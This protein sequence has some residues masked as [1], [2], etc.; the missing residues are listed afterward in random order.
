[1]ENAKHQPRTNNKLNG[2]LKME[3]SLRH[4]HIVTQLSATTIDITPNVLI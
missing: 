4:K 1:M 2:I 3:I